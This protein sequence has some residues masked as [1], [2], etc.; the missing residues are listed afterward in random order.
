MS[1]ELS[2]GLNI[3]FQN[4]EN[5]N[6]KYIID[7][8]YLLNIFS[9]EDGSK[10]FEALKKSSEKLYIPFIVWLELCYNVEKKITGT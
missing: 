4:G 1:K 8:N 3:F 10:Y 6:K 5:N 7:T 9:L 2:K